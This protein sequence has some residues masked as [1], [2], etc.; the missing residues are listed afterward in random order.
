MIFDRMDAKNLRGRIATAC[1]GE[2]QIE[3]TPI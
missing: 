2:D 3:L 1:A